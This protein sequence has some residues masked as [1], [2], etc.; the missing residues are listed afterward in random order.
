MNKEKDLIK[1]KEYIN[2]KKKSLAIDEIYETLGWS[3]KFK[4]ENK[5]ILDSWVED[6][7][8]FRNNRGRYNTPE[9]LGMIKGVMSIIKNRFAFV[10]TETE[11]IFI[12]RK[13]FN[14]ALDGDTVLVEITKDGKGGGKREGEK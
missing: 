3:P 13:G 8:L 5:K 9:N 12:P 1:L 2:H 4:K 14:G 10:D 7:E 6:G 11:G